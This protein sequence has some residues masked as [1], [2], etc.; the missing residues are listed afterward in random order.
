MARKF[1]LKKTF[2]F[3]LSTLLSRILGLIRE[4]VQIRYLGV[5]VLSDAFI[6]AYKLPNFLRRIFAEGALSAAF[7]PELVRLIKKKEQKAANGLMTSSFIFFEGVVLLICLFVIIFP[8][9][10]IAI[11]TPG[12]SGEQ[13]EYAIPLL[14]ILISLIF[15]LSSSALLGGALHSVNHFFITAFG[16][17]LMNVVYIL[18]L[19]ACIYYKL[20]VSYLAFGILLAG[21]INFLMHLII[22]FFYK[23]KFGKIIP[24]AVK[25]FKSVLGKFLPCL[26]GV[27]VVEL[28]LLIDGQISS[29]LPKGTYTI[30]YYGQR[31]MN[32]PLG[33]FA[34]AFSTVLLPHFS[35]VMLYAPRRMN[36]YLVEV[37]K[38]I[39]WIILP[40]IFFLF[41]TSEKLFVHLLTKY[42]D[43]VNEAAVILM[44]YSTGLIFFC[45]NKVLINMY[46][47]MKDTRT[48]TAMSAWS[49]GANIILNIAGMYFFGSYGIA[50]ATT[51]SGFILTWLLILNLDKKYDIR[52]HLNRFLIFISTY[53]VHFL[54]G[55]IFFVGLHKLACYLFSL[56]NFYHFFCVGLGYWIFTIPLFI[57]TMVF[58]FYIKKL[59]KLKVYF[60]D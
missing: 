49:T 42:P 18:T 40:T 15:F 7:V 2:E 30:L 50:A 37:V 17:A 59:F 33:M 51:I 39:T 27:G 13:V 21:A 53:I 10:I 14:R 55:M 12:F 20:P 16:P 52:F 11:F 32:I 29:F 22:F 19:L 28:N 43:S 38:F 41:F 56:F 44:I 45:V 25:S 60:L 46:Y 3:G 57:L 26:F 36:L 9:I 24:D 23:F 6:A 1:I 35:R 8:Q 31:F 58:M 47:S 5:G 48:P 34:V 54:V 4:A